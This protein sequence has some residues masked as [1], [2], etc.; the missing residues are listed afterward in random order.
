MSV[1]H[2]DVFE[3]GDFQLLKG[4]G[5]LG[6]VQVSHELKDFFGCKYVAGVFVP[7]ARDLGG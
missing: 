5:V 1:V 7:V 3:R 4:Q 2:A 6:V